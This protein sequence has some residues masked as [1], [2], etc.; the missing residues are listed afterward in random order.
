M[1]ESDA[2]PSEVLTARKT[3][4]EGWIQGHRDEINRLSADLK[5]HQDSIRPLSDQLSDLDAAISQLDAVKL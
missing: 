5:K 3:E 1:V 4:V 2:S